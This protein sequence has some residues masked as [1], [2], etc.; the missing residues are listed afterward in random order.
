MITLTERAAA[1]LKVLLERERSPVTALRL[2]VTAG[3]CSGLR[4]DLAFDEVR[5]ADHA[6]E[7]HGVA[8]VIDPKSAPHLAGCILDYAE[9]LNESGFQIENP[10]AETT[11]G[12][13]ES[14][15]V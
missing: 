14:F 15:G 6:L 4:Y 11:C 3:G 8:V 5:D 9:G 1:K 2:R 10:N 13:G 12:C 7:Q